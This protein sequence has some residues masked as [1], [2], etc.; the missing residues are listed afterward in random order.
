[1]K[2]SEQL[3]R[4]NWLYYRGGWNALRLCGIEREIIAY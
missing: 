4:G 3:M 1:M 2:L